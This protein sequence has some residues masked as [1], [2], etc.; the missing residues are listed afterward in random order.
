MKTM[1]KSTSRKTNRRLVSLLITALCMS[2]IA[3]FCLTGMFASATDPI[4]RY[5]ASLRLDD[6]NLTLQ[7]CVQINDASI[8]KVKLG[9]DLGGDGIENTEFIPLGA[10]NQ[11]DGY[12]YVFSYNVPAKD[13]ATPIILRA[14]N[15]SEE[16]V[17][18]RSIPGSV[19][20][21]ILSG[22]YSKT[23]NLANNPELRSAA[24]TYFGKHCVRKPDRQG[25]F[26][27]EFCTQCLEFSHLTW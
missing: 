19:L 15:A 18:K 27:G 12:N 4:R 24:Q 2:L 11:K 26:Y 21:Q 17:G 14:Y 20:R 3:T 9:R 23:K 8:T 13:V 25:H 6:Q 7:C 10:P 16:Q 1:A 5:G 22:L